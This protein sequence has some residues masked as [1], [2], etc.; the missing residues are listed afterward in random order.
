MIYRVFAIYDHYSRVLSLRNTPFWRLP[1]PFCSVTLK[2]VSNLKKEEVSQSKASTHFAPLMSPVHMVLPGVCAFLR[3]FA[4]YPYVFSRTS[5][6]LEKKTQVA[7]K[8]KVTI[9]YPFEKGPLSP[10]FRGEHAL[11]RYPSGEERCIACKLCEAI[12][13]AQVWREGRKEGNRT[14]T[15][16]LFVLIS[17][18]NVVLCVYIRV[19]VQQAKLLQVYPRKCS[20]FQAQTCKWFV[21]DVCSF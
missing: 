14:Y 18:I 17:Q 15:F 8:P 6:L 5:F 16:W 21:F 11:R 3:W 19:E 2:K 20:F 10:R 12:C 4:V 7:M 1:S 9:N 13:P